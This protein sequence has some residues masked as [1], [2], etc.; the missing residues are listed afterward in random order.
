MKIIKPFIPS[1]PFTPDRPEKKESILAEA[2]RATNGDRQENYGHPLANHLRI[3]EMWNGYLR[4]KNIDS[5]GEK[6][7]SPQIALD[8]HGVAMMMILLKCARELHTSK[9]DNA[10]DMVGYA[11]CLAMIQGHE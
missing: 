6:I 3:A 1:K 7:S 10:V 9:R 5:N 2:L 4:S 11:R 8:A